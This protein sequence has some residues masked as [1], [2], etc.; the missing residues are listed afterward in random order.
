MGRKEGRKERRTTEKVG[1]KGGDLG[2]RD[3][4]E[5]FFGTGRDEKGEE[6]GVQ[7]CRSRRS[8]ELRRGA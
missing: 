4:E 1:C 2:Y 8:S 6:G 5:A 7:R 3:R